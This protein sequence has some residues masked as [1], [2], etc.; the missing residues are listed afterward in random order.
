MGLSDDLIMRWDH[1]NLYIGRIW[2]GQVRRLVPGGWREWPMYRDPPTAD[3]PDH[4]VRNRR[5]MKDYHEQHEAAPWR[6]WLSSDEDGS[7]LGWYETESEA[8]FALEAVAIEA[9]RG[10]S[11]YA[12]TE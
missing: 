6:A 2:V 5:H 9:A 7:E 1:G 4:V 11:R 3:T 8:R 10:A 12:L